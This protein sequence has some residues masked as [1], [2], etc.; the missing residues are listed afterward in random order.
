MTAPDARGASFTRIA[1][2]ASARNLAETEPGTHH[3]T[4]ALKVRGNCFARLLDDETLVL[5]CPVDQKVLLMEIS[6]DI[7]HETEH[8]VGSDA[9][10]VNLG[11]IGDEELALRLADAW[12]FKAPAA[13]K[14]KTA[15]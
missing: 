12:T 9:V 5:Q 2:L 1:A 14:T 4:P 11:A 7:Y 6:P 15:V 13:L 10:L 8:Y 3:G